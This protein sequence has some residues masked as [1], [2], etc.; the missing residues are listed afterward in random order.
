[1]PFYFRF[2]SP[3]NLFLPG[4]SGSFVAVGGGFGVT[5]LLVFLLRL[6]LRLDSVFGML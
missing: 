2:Y 1:M 5:F 4:V 6:D 3:G